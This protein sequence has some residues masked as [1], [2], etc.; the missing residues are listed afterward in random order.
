M[1]TT[2]ET[3]KNCNKQTESKLDIAHRE[4][5]EDIQAGKF[6]IIKDVDGHITSLEKEQGLLDDV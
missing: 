3:V 1:S 5:M 4:A 6:T 2:P